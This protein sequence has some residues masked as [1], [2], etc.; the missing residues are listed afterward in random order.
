MI[1]LFSNETL[2]FQGTLSCLRGNVVLERFIGHFIIQKY[3]PSTLIVMMVMVGFWIPSNAYPARTALSITGLLALITQQMQASTLNVSYIMALNVWM[4][5]C[6]TFV[7]LSLIE[8]ALSVVWATRKE[9]RDRKRRENN[10]KLEQRFTPL[11]AS[12]GTDGK[13]VT[14]Q[15]GSAAHERSS[16]S[17]ISQGVASTPHNGSIQMTPTCEASPPPKKPDSICKILCM[18]LQSNLMTQSPNSVDT[19]ARI[20]FPTVFAIAAAFYY[21]YVASKW[22]RTY[23]L[24]FVCISHEMM[25]NGKAAT[26]SLFSMHQFLNYYI[27]FLVNGQ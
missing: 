3:I 24:I 11:S 19:V 10:E 18:K 5:I 4:L 25:I 15:P 20:V 8:L 21:G 7:F 12:L 27:T 1:Y 13:V 26:L 2:T 14:A 6:I 22:P 9:N 17:N 23:R 16:L